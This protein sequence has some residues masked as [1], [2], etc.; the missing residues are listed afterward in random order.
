MLRASDTLEI[1]I[2]EPIDVCMRIPRVPS[3]AID[4]PSVHDPE[5]RNDINIGLRNIGGDV[6]VHKLGN[7]D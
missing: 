1:L 3:S 7:E 6:R 5:V 2:V 4:L